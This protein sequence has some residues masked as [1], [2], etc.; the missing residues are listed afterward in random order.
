LTLAS[1]EL[2]LSRIQVFS[3]E[4]DTAT[5]VHVDTTEC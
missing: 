1:G 4:T 5:T 3:P 2:R